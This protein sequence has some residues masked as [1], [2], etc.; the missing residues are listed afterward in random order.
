MGLGEKTGFARDRLLECFF[1]AAGVVFDPRHGFCREELTKASALITTL[2][3][4]YD[5][6]GS[7]NEL[8][9]QRKSQCQLFTC[10]KDQQ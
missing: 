4:V 2:D 6:Y 8:M 5:V 7:L 10:L 9:L 1:C 3:D